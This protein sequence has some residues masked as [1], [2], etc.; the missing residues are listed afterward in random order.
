MTARHAIRSAWNAAGACINWNSASVM[1]VRLE[2]EQRCGDIIILK[3]EVFLAHLDTRARSELC[4][5][6]AHTCR[7]PI[8]GGKRIG[9]RGTQR[10]RE[11]RQEG[12]V[13]TLERCALTALALAKEKYLDL[14]FHPLLLPLLF[15]HFIDAIANA[16][17]LELGEEPAVAIC[18]RLIWGRLERGPEGIGHGSTAV[19]DEGD[20]H[21]RCR[22][23]TMSARRRRRERRARRPGPVGLGRRGRKNLCSRNKAE[24]HLPNWDIH[25]LTCHFPFNE[26]TSQGPQA[27]CGCAQLHVGVFVRFRHRSKVHS[28]HRYRFPSPSARIRVG[29][30]TP[31]R[32]FLITSA[33][34]SSIVTRVNIAGDIVPTT[35]RSRS[36]ASVTASC[37][38]RV[39]SDPGCSACVNTPPFLTMNH[40]LAQAGR[41]YPLLERFFLALANRHTE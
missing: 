23:S 26:L 24:K 10:M 31:F 20:V 1:S 39:A 11:R 6:S 28:G 38:P 18:G 2:W 9:T 35:Q 41:R 30:L 8:D 3:K 32:A 5:D 25:R 22:R 12:E 21:H 34:S 4:S 27:A 7:A 40:V 13:L 33:P 17:C 15:E 16:L 19:R 29:H 36:D 37:Q 14:L